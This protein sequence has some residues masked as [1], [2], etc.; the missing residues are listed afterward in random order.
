MSNP[1]Q[2]DDV[3]L[4]NMSNEDLLYLV[5]DSMTKN[6]LELLKKDIEEELELRKYKDKRVKQ[7]KLEIM[8]ETEKILAQSKKKTAKKEELESESESEEEDVKPKK[9]APAKKK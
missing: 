5:M 4:P 2:N 9:R 1:Q 8:K 6:D 3:F 7:I